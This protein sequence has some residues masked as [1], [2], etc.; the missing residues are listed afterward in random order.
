MASADPDLILVGGGLASSLIAWRL[1][2]DRPDIRVLVVERD[3]RLGGK[4]TWSFFDGDV[5]AEDRAWL[6]PATP[7]RWPDGYEVYFP[8]LSRTLKTPYNS[9]TS[10]RLHEAVAPLLEDRLVTGDAVEVRT[11]GITLADGRVLTAPAVI[12]AR[13][14]RPTSHLD[15]GWQ[16]F[17][18]RTVRLTQPHGL[19]RPTIMDATVAQ[20]DAYRFVYLLPFDAR[21]VLIEDTYY[22]DAATLDRALLNRRIDAYIRSRGWTVEAV[23]DEEE[24]VLPIALD[25]DI[26]GFWAEG[27]DVAKVGLAGALFH[28]TTGYSLPDAVAVARLVAGADD[29]SSAGLRR[30][31]EGYS[32]RLWADRAYYRLL[33]RMLFRA[34][35]P[36]ERWR[37]LRRFYGLSEALVRRFYAGR[38]TALDKV[39][40][41]AG[42][43]PVPV[44]RAMKQ[45]RETG[46][47]SL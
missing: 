28:P 14:P 18:G 27:P 4:H 47:G 44:G 1:A 5:S 36:G 42:K 24:G 9:L 30:L 39:R 38:S 45:L 46:K 26:D 6:E 12:D 10:D 32:K 43:P 20:G 40:I 25:G 29:L 23:T 33:D 2:I 37:V 16:L 7:H 19:T 8:G 17:V 21:T 31:V 15:L 13:G 35:D 3:G 34:A 11:D 22:V 41:L